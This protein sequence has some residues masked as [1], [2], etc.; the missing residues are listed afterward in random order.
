MGLCRGC[1]SGL[2]AV[3]LSWACAQAWADNAVKLPQGGAV[4]SDQPLASRMAAEVL[5]R[6]GNAVDAAVQASLVQA[7]LAPH[8]SG[9]GGGALGLVRLSSGQVLVFDGRET[10]PAL[11]GP[12]MYFRGGQLQAA[13][14]E[15][16]ALSV[17]TPGFLAALY[18]MH[19][20]G[21][22]WRWVDVVKPVADLAR[23]GVSLSPGLAAVAHQAPGP[24]QGLEPGAVLVQTELADTL[25]SIAEKGPG[26]F[27]RGDFAK[28]LEHLM[29]EQEGIVSSRDLERYKG[30]VRRPSESQFQGYVL[31][32]AGLPA[33]GSFRSQ[34]ILALLDAFP[35]AKLQAA[36]PWHLAAE[37]SRLALNDRPYWLGDSDQVK[38]PTGF[39]D[40]LTTRQMASLINRKKRLAPGDLGQDFSQEPLPAQ[41]STLVSDDDGNWVVLVASLNG[42]FGSGLTVPGTG[43]VLNNAMAAF[44]V[45]PLITPQGSQANN[46][47]PGKRP[48]WSTT[49]WLASKL[50]KPQLA[51][52]SQGGMRGASEAA[53]VAAW[54]LAQ[55]QELAKAG[56]N[57]RVFAPSAQQPLGLIGPWPSSLQDDLAARGQTVQPLPP[58]PHLR[59]MSRV[60]GDLAL[61]Y[62]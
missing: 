32:G 5:H 59:V 41:A 56:A 27:Y 43:V 24:W 60:S 36:E 23:Q 49:L 21:G 11:A 53:Q 3:L 52:A 17:A 22:R 35:W 45:N 13:L 4:I 48:L 15:R 1:W 25:L 28:A 46:I 57:L 37:A 51:L 20:R 55:G 33:T 62:E 7:V 54:H 40:P 9:L 19:K 16:G 44:S 31:Q 26:A 50:G 10:A 29:L 6:G 58:R 12:A 30:Q 39:L 42:V 2:L 8:K 61:W 14:S 18:E 38:V 47:A 34:Q